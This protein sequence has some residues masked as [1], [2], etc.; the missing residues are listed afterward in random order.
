MWSVQRFDDISYSPW[1]CVD[2]ASSYSVW[3]NCA[4]TKCGGSRGRHR[5]RP[6]GNVGRHRCHL[7]DH[8]RCKRN[9]PHPRSQRSSLFCHHVEFRRICT[10]SNTWFFVVS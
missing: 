10:V 1:C 3:F 2:H 7:R 5:S 9:R 6:V 4:F 8:I